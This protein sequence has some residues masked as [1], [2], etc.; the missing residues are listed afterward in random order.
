[1]SLQISKNPKTAASKPSLSYHWHE[2]LPC[3]SPDRSKWISSSEENFRYSKNQRKG[4]QT[5]FTQ[6]YPRPQIATTKTFSPFT[7]RIVDHYSLLSLFKTF[8]KNSHSWCY[9]CHQWK[10]PPRSVRCGIEHWIIEDVLVKWYN[11]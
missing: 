7:R 6:L 10:K 9:I 3:T 4:E 5:L 11:K 1:M 2:V 8:L